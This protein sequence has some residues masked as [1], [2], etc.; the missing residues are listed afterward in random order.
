MNNDVTIGLF[1]I[2]S[3]IT[4]ILLL[5]GFSYETGK[6]DLINELCSKQQYDFCIVDTYKLKG[7]E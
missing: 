1:V 2:V 6:S 3:F 5:I 4:A 7:E